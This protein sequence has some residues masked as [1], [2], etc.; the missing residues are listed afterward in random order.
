LRR[1]HRGPATVR[2]EG[3][4]VHVGADLAERVV[5]LLRSTTVRVAEL[6]EPSRHPDDASQPVGAG[7]RAKV[8][9]ERIEGGQ[10]LGRQ[11]EPCHLALILQPMR[12]ARQDR[13][14]WT[15]R[16]SRHPFVLPQFCPSADQAS[17]RCMHDL[18]FESVPLDMAKGDG[19]ARWARSWPERG[20]DGVDA[21]AKGGMANLHR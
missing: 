9:A 7:C 2:G 12:V 13:P 5:D 6:E 10:L 19:P 14:I 8:L 4:L 17:N 20:K 15:G 21:E 11:T 18:R 3:D 16:I 1:H